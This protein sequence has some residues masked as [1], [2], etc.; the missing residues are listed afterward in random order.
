MTIDIRDVSQFL[1]QHSNGADPLQLKRLGA[2]EP[3]VQPYVALLCQPNGTIDASHARVGNADPEAGHLMYASFLAEAVERQAQ[4]VVAPEYSVPWTVIRDIA[5]TAAGQRPPQGSLWILGCESI[6]PA[7]LDD[8]QTAVA[9]NAGLRLMHE[10]F[11]P[12]RR[13]Q[14]VFV[15]PVVLI[16]WAIDNANRNVLCLLVQF[17]TVVSR[18]PDHVELQSLYLGRFVYKFTPQTG[19]VSLI[20]LICSDAFEFTNELVDQH[21]NNLLLVH[22]QLNQKPAY[23]DYAAYRSRLFSVASNSNVEVICLN[24]AANLMITGSAN[25]WNAVAGSAWYVA[26]R[27]VTLD[28]ANVNELHRHGLYYSIVGLRW[29]AFYL[30]YAAHSLVVRKQPVYAVGPQIL[31]PRIPPQVTARRTWDATAGTWRDFAANDGF[32]AFIQ[33]YA[34]LD[35]MLPQMC[36]ND[37]LAVERALELLEGPPGSVSEWYFVKELSSLKVAGEESICRVT[38]SQE[39][40]PARQ[41]VEFRR[42]RARLAQ[43]AATIPGQ[44]IDWPTPVKDLAG[45]FRYRWLAAEPH[46]NVEPVAGGRPAAFVYLGEDPEHD[47][48]ANM[49][50]K[51]SK[52]RQVHAVTAAINAGTNASDAL[53]QAHDR[54]CVAYRDNHQLRFYLDSGH[55]SITDATGDAPDDIAG[56]KS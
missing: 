3:R 20:T 50:A 7:E 51:L 38:V 29:H 35:G 12:Q 53:I 16:F 49:W 33:S 22:I 9:G 2:L 30:N 8:L 1:A 55:A 52:A 15:D 19:D 32:G 10:P 11:D 25:P 44:G 28:D 17:K 47:R 39:V 21:A 45:G 6:T 23:V 14:S 4:L 48:R 31:A 26:P 34:P 56:E 18:D 41:G 54:L 42:R 24:W 43:T 27:G 5:L 37:P 40:D 36:Q 46:D 13:A